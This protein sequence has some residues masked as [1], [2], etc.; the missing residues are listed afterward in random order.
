[1]RIW[2][3]IEKH[4]R[5]L[6]TQVAPG[7]TDEDINNASCFIDHNEFG[8]AFEVI[9]DQLGEYDYQISEE[10][11][12]LIRH[13]AELMNLDERTWCHLRENIR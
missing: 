8:V 4:L 7:L 9:C 1:M 10:S 5:I 2:K 3:T 6:M 12:D 13:L 11:L